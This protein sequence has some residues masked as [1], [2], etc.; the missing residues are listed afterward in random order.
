MDF[1]I[2][3]KIYKEYKEI[4]I[5]YLVIVLGMLVYFILI[6]LALEGYVTLFFLFNNF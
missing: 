1:S 3:S 4:L 5:A 6:Y 2:L